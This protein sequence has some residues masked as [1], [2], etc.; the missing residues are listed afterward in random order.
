MLKHQQTYNF[1]WP[2]IPETESSRSPKIPL[3]TVLLMK[4][5]TL[6]GGTEVN[7]EADS[8]AGSQAVFHVGS[9]SGPQSGNQNGS[10]AGLD[11]AMQDAL[12]ECQHPW[13]PRKSRLALVY[14]PAAIY[15]PIGLHSDVS[16]LTRGG[17]R[18][19]VTQLS[20]WSLLWAACVHVC[21]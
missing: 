7:S 6:S 5:G 4:L 18:L 14:Q 12:N 3:E 10:Q 11:A 15:S 16:E 20:T 21:T 13:S 1:Y 2:K 17:Y 8:Q 9:Q 19:C